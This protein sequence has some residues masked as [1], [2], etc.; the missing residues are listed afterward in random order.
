[1]F[2]AYHMAIIIIIII[3][4]NKVLIKVTLNKVI[5]EALYIVICGSNTVKVQSWQ[6]TDW[7]RDVSK[8]RRK[9]SSDG[10]SLTAAGRLFH[11]RD[12][13]TG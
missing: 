8:R 3:I 9:H 5:A 12:A 11:A 4:I 6:L 2:Q 7:N 10:V 13:A 1:M